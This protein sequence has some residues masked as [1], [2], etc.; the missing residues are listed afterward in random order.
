MRETIDTTEADELVTSHVPLVRHI[1][2]ETM[3]RVPSHVNR[4]DLTSAGLMA[5]VKASRSFDSAR[6]VPFARYAATRVRGAILDEL[7]ATDWASRQV[8]RRAREL[9]SARAELAGTLGR[10][11]SS[12]DLAETLGV[13]VAEVD[14]NDDDV[15]RAHVLSVEGLQELGPDD[16]IRS[17]IPTPEE[18][19]VH[20]ER[21][22][23]LVEAVAELPERLR[24]VVSAYFLQER[25]M[26]EIAA[27]LGVTESRVSQMRAE[28]LVLL[29]DALNHE[30]DP[31]NVAE[32]PRPGGAAA[33]RRETYFAAVASRHA[34][35]RTSPAR[36]SLVAG[37]PADPVT[38]D[39]KLA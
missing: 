5:L 22:T 13:S 17:V 39:R 30:L 18:E 26:V 19:A 38:D 3:G 27:E 10:A 21:L 37:G 12:E 36:L 7:R 9:A 33:R 8:R 23:Y 11:P 32:H 1:V 28:A 15:A 4:D 31:A 25:P 6:G 24:V 16:I 20:R 35:H 29:R 14:R 2:R 34:T